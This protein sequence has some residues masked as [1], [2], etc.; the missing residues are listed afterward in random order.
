M[1]RFSYLQDGS[2]ITH[3]GPLNAKRVLVL[4]GRDNAKA[5]TTLIRELV[6]LIY[7][8][9]MTVIFYE[10]P[11]RKIKFFKFYWSAIIGQVSC[12]K[13]IYFYLLQVIAFIK[14]IHL[15]N[16]FIIKR[17]RRQ[18][19]TLHARTESLKLFLQRFSP[20]QRI[21]LLTQSAGARIASL[22]A[23]EVGVDRM[24]CLGYPFCNPEEGDN[25][26][27]YRHLET[28]T[29]PLLIFQ[30]RHDPY[31]GA[32]VL[33]MYKVSPSVTI[34]IVDTDHDFKLA[35]HDKKM[36]AD[37]MMLHYTNTASNKG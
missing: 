34:H 18:W 37:H 23:D 20:D 12:I 25:I 4:I 13:S 1:L 29:T 27:R 31:G 9:N 21:Q 33:T 15:W 8:K 16:R 6:S 7:Q 35:E 10:C 3:L 30:G 11:Y 28:L 26:D 32:E 19:G 14:C 24:V 36:M 5:D 2:F 17:Y 22:I